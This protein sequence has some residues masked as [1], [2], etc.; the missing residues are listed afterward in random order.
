M[1]KVSVDKTAVLMAVL[2]AVVEYHTMVLA[3]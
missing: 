1:C 3:K 2:A